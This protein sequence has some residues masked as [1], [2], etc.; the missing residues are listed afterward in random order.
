MSVQNGLKIFDPSVTLGLI[1]NYW[2]GRREYT[3]MNSQSDRA[4]RGAT[5]KTLKVRTVHRGG[6]HVKH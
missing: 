3:E 5:C 1:C 2:P 6:R 4:P